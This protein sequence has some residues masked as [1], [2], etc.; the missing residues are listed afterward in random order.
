LNYNISIEYVKNTSTILKKEL[1]IILDGLK[2]IGGLPKWEA[3]NF[4]DTSH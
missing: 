4:D 1:L 3:Y 2:E